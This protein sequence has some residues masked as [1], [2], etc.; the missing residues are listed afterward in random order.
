MAQIF[1]KLISAER[2]ESRER[3]K[4]RNIVLRLNII[5]LERYISFLYVKL[6]KVVVVMAYS[7]RVE[8]VR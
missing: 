3:K 2:Y 8:K 5:D 7:E 4:E 1:E 6:R